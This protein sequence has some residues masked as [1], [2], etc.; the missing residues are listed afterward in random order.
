M[1]ET[2][3]IVI[4]LRYG[5][6]PYY[7]ESSNVNHDLNTVMLT[8]ADE[9]EALRRDLAAAKAE[10]VRLREQ[11]AEWEEWQKKEDGR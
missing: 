2:N 4:R 6:D 7:R 10:N 9:I 8:A 11:I 1:S 3:D 5:E